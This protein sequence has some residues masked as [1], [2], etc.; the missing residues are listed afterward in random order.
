[1]NELKEYKEQFMAAD[2]LAGEREVVP[3]FER[4]LSASR[5]DMSGVL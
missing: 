2:D 3:C 1:M 5:S 4:F